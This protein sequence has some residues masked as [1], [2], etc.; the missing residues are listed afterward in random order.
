MNQ[1]RG[2]NCA[3]SK[4]FPIF[5]FY[6]QVNLTDSFTGYGNIFHFSHA[7]DKQRFIHAFIM[8]I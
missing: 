4:P 6:F 3:P 2:M 8:K 5:V 7:A 1:Y